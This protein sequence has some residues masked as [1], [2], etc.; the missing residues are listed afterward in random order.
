MEHAPAPPEDAPTEKDTHTETETEAEADR[1][2]RKEDVVVGMAVQKRANTAERVPPPPD[3]LPSL[4]FL[5]SF[6][7]LRMSLRLRWS[8]TCS[9]WP[10]TPTATWFA[11]PLRA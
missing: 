10:P 6:L 9:E 3:P 2:L 5:G 8:L 4:H 11:A 1:A 7:R